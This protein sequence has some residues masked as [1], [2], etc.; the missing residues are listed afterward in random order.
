MIRNQPRAAFITCLFETHLR[1]QNLERSI[2]FY[3]TTLGLELG[4][5]EQAR[6]VAFFWIGGQGKS[7]LGLWENPPWVSA[8]NTTGQIIT[9]L[10][11]LRLN[12]RIWAARSLASRNEG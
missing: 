1:V 10:S 7:V 6:R 4:M 3:E 11:L 8:G 5:K 2:E 12:A 9:Q